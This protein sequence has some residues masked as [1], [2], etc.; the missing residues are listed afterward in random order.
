MVPQEVSQ[1]LSPACLLIKKLSPASDKSCTSTGSWRRRTLA[2]RDDSRLEGMQRKIN[3]EQLEL[4]MYLH[5]LCGSW[6]NH[7][8]WNSRFLLERP[9]DLAKLRSSSIR[10]VW[11][12]TT[13]GRDIEVIDPE[14]AAAEA[15]AITRSA[16]KLRT[17][18][19]H[20]PATEEFGR[21][22]A[23]C[24]KAKTAVISMFQE[25][26][27]GRAVDPEQLEPLI[28]E[29]TASVRR[30]ANALISL[31]RLKS[32]DDY[33]YMH[34]VAVSGLM[35]ALARQLGMSDD[36]VHDAAFG[37]MLHD[38]G[39]ASMPM[40]VLNK[41]GKLTEDEFAIIRGHPEA[42]AKMLEATGG[43]H[44][45]AVDICLHHHEKLDGTGYPH[46]LQGD[47]ISMLARMGAVCDVYDAITSNRP[48][49]AGW[50]PGES[51]RRMNQ[52]TGSHLDT[53]VFH[54]FVKT[55][56]IYPIGSLVKLESGMLGVVIDQ[57]PNNTIK[58]LLR[59]F[60]STRSR[61]YLSPARTVD[62]AAAGCQDN[63]VSWELP[64]T[65][66][67]KN[68]DAYWKGE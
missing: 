12:D 18:E 56:G 48:Y 39:K 16:A 21:A 52:W 19:A 29:I 25:A 49:K 57:N 66:G 37:G 20:V 27:M 38:L 31:A 59:V 43:A 24:D 44:P 64:E 33:T 36:E 55:L 13:K 11:I 5:Q 7:P 53:Q 54:A 51:V 22:A 50:A 10:E 61:A 2:N 65:W 4:G 15:E 34:S 40:D 8:F 45:S 3:I 9:E 23:I 28:N 17:E 62:L 42:G 32:V 68:F 14:V 1:G 35:A 30:N 46:R 26:R 63:I 58:P 41:P 6:M 60:F 47:A 67:I